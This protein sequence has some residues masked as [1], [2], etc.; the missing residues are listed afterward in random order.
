MK[1]NKKG[2]IHPAFIIIGLIALL[3]IVPLV[4]SS[5]KSSVS[6]SSFSMADF[7]TDSKTFGQAIGQDSLGWLS[8]IF[9]AVPQALI[10]ATSE[11]GGAIVIFSVWVILVLMFGDILSLFGTFSQITGTTR[12][13]ATYTYSPIAWIIAVALAIIAANFKVIMMLASFGFAFVSGI[14]VLAA[15]LGVVTPFLVYIVIHVLFLGNLR[16]WAHGKIT[17]QQF[18]DGMDDMEKGIKGAK[19]F[20]QA[21]RNP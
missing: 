10:D 1:M 16:K 6:G 21:V 17:G 7:L 8:Y 12:G 2:M 18:Y 9:G 13:G 14:G 3:I 11:K 15:L 5:L 20:G 19:K 4:W